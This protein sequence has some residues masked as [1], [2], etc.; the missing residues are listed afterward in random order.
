MSK[1]MEDKVYKSYG[2]DKYSRPH[3][4]RRDKKLWISDED[5]PLKPPKGMRRMMGAAEESVYRRGGLS[6]RMMEKMLN[7][8]LGDLWDDVY[9][10]FC[11]Q[12][13]PQNY[14]GSEFKDSLKGWMLELN[15]I[16]VNGEVCDSKG[17]KLSTSYPT[18]YVHPET[19]RL[20]KT[21]VQKRKWKA[22]PAKQII[23]EVDGT[24]F[25]QHENIWYRVEMVEIE[26]YPRRWPTLRWEAY[27]KNMNELQDAFLKMPLRY[28]DAGKLRTKY[29]LSPNKK[30]WYCKLKE[31]A[32]S[33]EIETLKKK[34][35]L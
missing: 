34:F 27:C 15:C 28:Y 21:D 10:D 17:E 24:N 19:K 2:R 1:E 13:N 25:Y 20:E 33:K 35:S 7:N 30:P 9:S 4:P 5:G 29:G 11:D 26:E 16:M 8:K 3:H 12:I 18:Y 22:R 6:F 31:S 23:F 32:N 14:I